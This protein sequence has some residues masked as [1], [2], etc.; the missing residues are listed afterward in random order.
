L[1]GGILGGLT[2]IALKKAGYFAYL[3]E[4]K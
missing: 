1:L 2:I 4:K 3:A